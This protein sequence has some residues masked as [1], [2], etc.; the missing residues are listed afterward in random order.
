MEGPK[1]NEP[2]QNRPASPGKAGS[3]THQSPNPRS[4]SENPMGGGACGEGKSGSDTCST[5]DG[6]DV[7]SDT[8]RDT[9]A[10][11]KS[12]QNRPGSTGQ[13][14]PGSTGPNRPGSTGHTTKPDSKPGGGTG[15][16]E[17]EEEE[18]EER[19]PSGTKPSEKR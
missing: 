9:G 6:K 11:D 17:D 19:R 3:S 10:A 5:G 12:A 2:G 16:D 14:R 8:R 15:T 4:G 7:Q 18:P 1:K 13:Q